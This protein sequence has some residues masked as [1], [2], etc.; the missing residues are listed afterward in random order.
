MSMYISEECSRHVR[1]PIRVGESG[2]PSLIHAQNTVSLR[3]LWANMVMP[4]SALSVRQTTYSV[5]GELAKF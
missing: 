1:A 2:L 5:S 3:W 4:H